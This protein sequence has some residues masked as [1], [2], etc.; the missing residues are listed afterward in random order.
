VQ[1]APSCLKIASEL[2]DFTRAESSQRAREALLSRHFRMEYDPPEHPR[3]LN[4]HILASIARVIVDALHDLSS[5]SEDD[6][7]DGSSSRHIPRRRRVFAR[8]DYTHSQYAQMLIHQTHLQPNTRDFRDFR[9]L[10]RVPPSFFEEH[11]A[12]FTRLHDKQ[13]HDCVGQ[14]AV[15][16]NLKVLS[17]FIILSSGLSFDQMGFAIGCDGETL[18]VFFHYFLDMIVEHKA[19]IWIKLPTTQAELQAAVQTY[20]SENLPGCMGSIDCTH[21][22]WVRARDAVRSWFI[23]DSVFFFSCPLALSD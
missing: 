23:G 20:A 15:P 6:A 11:V 18:R 22:G 14:P 19:P 8:K 9:L 1:Y 16:L 7:G 5:E 12:F 17:V 3:V 10:F 2:S 13:A 4:V 21:I